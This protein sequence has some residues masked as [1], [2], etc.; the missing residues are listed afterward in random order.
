MNQLLS[1]ILNDTFSQAQLKHRRRILK[2]KLLQTF[3]G[4]TESLP[5]SPQDF[6][7]LQ[8]LPK[9][10]YQQFNKD[11]VYH[12]FDEFD[13]QIQKLTML[14]LYLTFEPDEASLSQIGTFAR[15]TF[16]QNM[17]LD[18][19]FDPNLIAGCALSFKGI[20]KDYSLRAK[21]E[22]RKG[23]M[24]EGFKKFLR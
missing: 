10:F 15:K 1:T 7:W 17:L 23:E 9:E 18:I 24:L 13:A 3:F 20:Y 19:K 5:L 21:I 11:N 16:S 12:I 8:S 6:N 14:T 4:N 2:S 22:S